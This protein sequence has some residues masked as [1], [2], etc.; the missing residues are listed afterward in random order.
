M[1]DLLDLGY[2]GPKYTWNNGREGAD[3]TM[4][5]LDRMVANRGLCD[6]YHGV[7]VLVR[8]TICSDHSPLFVSLK[9]H[10]NGQ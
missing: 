7:E 6:L 10:V 9:G 4:E 2:R 1:C 3:F 8:V 5:R